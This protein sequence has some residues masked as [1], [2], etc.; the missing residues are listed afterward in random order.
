MVFFSYTP[1]NS[2]YIS[3]SIFSWNQS[4]LLSN[5]LLRLRNLVTVVSSIAFFI[6][7]F[8]CSTRN[9]YVF[10]L[11]ACM[12]AWILSIIEFS[13]EFLNSWNFSSSCGHGWNLALIPSLL[14]IQLKDKDNSTFEY[15]GNIFSMSNLLCVISKVSNL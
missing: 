2:S 7:S 14:W 9:F 4:I 8:I 1:S 10:S 13:I 3:L 15:K 6:A 11:F 5:C 12:A